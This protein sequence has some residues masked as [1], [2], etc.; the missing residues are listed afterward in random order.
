MAEVKSYIIKVITYK[1]PAVTLSY[2]ASE[3]GMVGDCPF[4]DGVRTGRL[5]K[6]KTTTGQDNYM[7]LWCVDCGKQTGLLTV[8]SMEFV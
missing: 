5:F 3:D 2:F 8:V 7:E 1:G 6:V 4:C